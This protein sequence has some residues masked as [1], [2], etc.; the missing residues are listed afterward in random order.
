[1]VYFRNY[2]QYRLTIVCAKY[3]TRG[4]H[5]RNSITYCHMATG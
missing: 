1:M 4:Q 3:F 5:I 2:I